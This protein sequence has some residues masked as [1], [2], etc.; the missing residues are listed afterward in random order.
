[1]T[2]QSGSKE[3]EPQPAG[4][5]QPEPSVPPQAAP[6]GEGEPAGGAPAVDAPPPQAPEAARPAA[7]RRLVQGCLGAI[8][9]AVIGIVIVAVALVWPDAGGL[10]TYENRDYDYTVGYPE[11]WDIDDDEPDVVVIEPDEA[12]GQMLVQVIDLDEEYSLAELADLALDASR[13]RM[14][15][16][17][18]LGQRTIEIRSGQRGR[19]IEMTYDNPDDRGGILRSKLLLVPV[20]ETVYQ[21]EVALLEEDWDSSFDDLADRVL[22]SLE[23]EE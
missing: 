12:N 17:E 23:I 1:M 5:E 4:Q 20:G 9:T 2:E 22:E 14:D 8:G 13:A 21:V 11:G 10:A 7:G 6:A 19:V 18:E 16:L 3:Q 15:D